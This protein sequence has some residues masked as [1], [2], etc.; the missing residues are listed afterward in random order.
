MQWEE[1][2]LRLRMLDGEMHIED[3]ELL[4]MMESEIDGED[5]DA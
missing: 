4:Q 1:T 2:L 3:S 5:G